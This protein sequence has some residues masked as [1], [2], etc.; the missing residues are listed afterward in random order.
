MSKYTVPD[1]AELVKK[2]KTFLK[3]GSFEEAL[4]CFEQ[5]LLLEQ[6]NAEIWNQKGATLRSLGRYNEAL[7]C[8]NKALE[9][10]PSDKYAS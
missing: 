10:D 6:N 1:V 3:E 8:F 9:L 7:E 2:G 5:A 4:S